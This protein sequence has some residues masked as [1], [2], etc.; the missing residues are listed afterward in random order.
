MCQREQLNQD[1][2]TFMNVSHKTNYTPDSSCS[3]GGSDHSGHRKT[4]AVEFL[5]NTFLEFEIKRRH[6]NQPVDA[7]L[8]L[9]G[10]PASTI[11]IRNI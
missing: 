11:T 3:N 9:M 5:A 7:E 6:K 4:I 1:E 10:T 8:P 2:G